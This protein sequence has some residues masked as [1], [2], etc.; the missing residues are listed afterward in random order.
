MLGAPI[1]EDAFTTRARS[2]PRPHTTTHKCVPSA[3]IFTYPH[4]DAS[5]DGA[6]LT[7]TKGV[8]SALIVEDALY[9]MYRTFAETSD[10]HP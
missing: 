9:H 3:H 5:I 10:Y 7:L 8:P 2:S 4:R 1:I 6:Q